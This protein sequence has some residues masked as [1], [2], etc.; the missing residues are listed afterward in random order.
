MIGGVLDD[1]FEMSPKVQILI[2]ILAGLAV[3]ITGSGLHNRVW[4]AC[5]IATRKAQSDSSNAPH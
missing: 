3:V 5:E 1:R 4:I 2:Q